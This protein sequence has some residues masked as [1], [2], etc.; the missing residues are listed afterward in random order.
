M[1]SPSDTVSPV[2]GQEPV[3]GLT[4]RRSDGVADI[5]ELAS[6]VGLPV[7]PRAKAASV[8]AISSTSAGRCAA[9]DEADRG[10]AAPAAHEGPAVDAHQVAVGQASVVRGSRGQ[11]R[12]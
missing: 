5:T 7:M 1:H 6:R 3:A 11:R 4:G 8:A 10:V 9:D 2:M 12:R